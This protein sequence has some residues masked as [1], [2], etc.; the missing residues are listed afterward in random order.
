MTNT[1]CTNPLTNYLFK[2]HISDFNP[3]TPRRRS[4]LREYRKA[5]NTRQSNRNTPKRT[6]LHIYNIYTYILTFRK[7][8]TKLTRFISRNDK[9]FSFSFCCLL[10]TYLYTIYA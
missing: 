5:Q 2:P 8:A 7:V 3:S 9:I 4:T 6:Y 1:C 10:H